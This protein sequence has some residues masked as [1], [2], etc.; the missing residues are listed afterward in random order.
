MVGVPRLSWHGN[1]EPTMKTQANLRSVAKDAKGSRTTPKKAA[2]C[3]RPAVARPS[4]PEAKQRTKAAAKSSI[5]PAEAK[6]KLPSKPSAKLPNTKPT[7]QF[8]L[9]SAMKRSQGATIN[10]LAVASGWQAHSVRGY[11]SG[12]LKKRMELNIVSDF[13]PGRGRVYRLG[14]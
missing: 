6:L 8:R 10:E 3:I 13:V 12:T 1:R 4:A 11:I 5:K 2:M 7:K 9:L 14:A